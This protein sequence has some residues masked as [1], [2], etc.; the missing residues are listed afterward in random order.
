MVL[1]SRPWFVGFVLGWVVGQFV[2]AEI[3]MEGTSELDTSVEG[4]A[5]LLC[6]ARRSESGL[7]RVE[8]FSDD[9]PVRIVR[10]LVERQGKNPG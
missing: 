8:P 4:S 6:I 10:V 5:H 7:T 2:E 3:L 9:E 1:Q